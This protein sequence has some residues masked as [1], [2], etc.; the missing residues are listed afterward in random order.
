MCYDYLSTGDS[1]QDWMAVVAIV[2]SI[3]PQVN[4]ELPHTTKVSLQSDNAKCYHNRSLMF[5]VF[6]LFPTYGLSLRIF[7]H[8]QTQH[9]KSSIDGQFTIL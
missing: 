6:M 2:E 7:V 1:K 8:S 4:N 5:G 9:G 3:E